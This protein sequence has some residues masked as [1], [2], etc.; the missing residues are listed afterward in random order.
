MT[1][2]QS[3]PVSLIDPAFAKVRYV[4]RQSRGFIFHD[5]GRVGLAGVLVL[6]GNSTPARWE[7][8]RQYR[9]ALHPEKTVRLT[10]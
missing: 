10:Q 7:R 8:S 1:R 3:T 4:F 6:G 2:A 5:I 9:R